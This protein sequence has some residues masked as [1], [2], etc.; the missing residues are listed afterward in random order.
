MSTLIANLFPLLSLLL[1]GP[2]GSSWTTPYCSTGLK[3]KY[4]P[5]PPPPPPALP[6]PLPPPSPPPPFFTRT[7]TSWLAAAGDRKQQRAPLKTDELK[8]PAA[9]TPFKF[10][11]FTHSCLSLRSWALTLLQHLGSGTDRRLVKYKMCCVFAQNVWMVTAKKRVWCSVPQQWLICI[12]GTLLW[13]PT[14]S[15]FGRS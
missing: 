3:D 1:K 12:Q 10:P 13:V 14:C 5:P 2:M 4:I 9:N 11:H 15:R 7:A 8:E 6:P